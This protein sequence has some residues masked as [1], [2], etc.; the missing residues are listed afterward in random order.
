MIAKMIAWGLNRQSA[1]TRLTEALSR[2]HVKGLKTNLKFLRSLLT[3]PEVIKTA[4]D[5]DF[6]DR[7][8]DQREAYTAPQEIYL[9]TVLWLF[10]VNALKTEVSPWTQQDGWRLNA[11][12]IQFFHFADGGTVSLACAA[13]S[14]K[15]G[16]NGKFYQ[17]YEV[18]ITSDNDVSA[19]IDGN[20]LQAK[21]NLHEEEIQI[22]FGDQVHYLR[23]AELNGHGTEAESGPAHLTA[24]MPGRV[25]SVMVAINESVMAGQPLLILEAMKM[26]HTIRAPH[27][28]I[29]EYLPFSS[30]DFCEEGVELVRLRES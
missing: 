1:L 12:A 3:H 16:W 13:D 25:V 10:H 5:I 19:T 22:T 21:I 18:C 7:Y 26:E 17:A 6:I 23:Q 28:G 15:M 14:L 29:V 4:P 20:H 2:T 8:V 30:G 27:E 24:P 11:P 9:L